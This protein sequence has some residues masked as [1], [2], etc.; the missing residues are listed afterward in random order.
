MRCHQSLEV[1]LVAKKFLESSVTELSSIRG[2]LSRART[3]PSHEVESG[4]KC[5]GW[6]TVAKVV[7]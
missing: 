3:P 4:V 6:T 1:V 5:S 2:G 7:C